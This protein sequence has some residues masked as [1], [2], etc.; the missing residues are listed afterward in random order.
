MHSNDSLVVTDFGAAFGTKV[1]LADIEFSLQPMTITVL[2]GPTG[3]GKSTLLHSLAGTYQDHPRYRS[4]GEVRYQGQALSLAN[5]ASLVQQNARALATT[6]LDAIVGQVRERLGLSPLEL[7]LWCSDYVRRMGFPDLVDSLD[8]AFMELPAVQMRAVN[9]LREAVHEPALLLVDEPTADLD[10]YDAYLLIELLKQV[11]RTSTLLVV[12]HNQKQARQLA[13][14]VIL[15]AGG[16]VQEARDTEDFF[17]SPISDAGAQFIRTGS[18]A[19]A[20]PDADPRTLEEGVAAPP[21]LPPQALAGIS[22]AAGAQ[23]TLANMEA[24]PAPSAALASGGPTGFTWLVPGRIAGA[25]MPGVVDDIDHDL[26]LLKRVG[27]T[28]LITLTERDVDQP[29]LARHGLKNV[30][31]P[32]YDREAPSLGQIQMLLKRMEILLVKG[33]AL[34]VHCLGG[35]GRTGTVLTA[36]LIREGLTAQEALRRVRLLDPR[37]VQSAEQEAFL[38]EYEELI[39]QKII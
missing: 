31:L 15:L 22:A 7:K 39:L 23:Q 37:Y 29:A 3:S 25:A 19:N 10:D 11:S 38:R 4:W 21:P 13:Q 8:K 18:C 35:L 12:L 36:W 27:I 24:A 20:S 5:R 28:M 1:V 17:N 6:V 32:V 34:A 16:R 14:R 26:A 9:I 30:H 33:E 2:M